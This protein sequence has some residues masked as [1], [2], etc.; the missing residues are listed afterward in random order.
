MGKRQHPETERITQ[1][2]RDRIKSD[3]DVKLV[4]IERDLRRDAGRGEEFRQVLILGKTVSH[5]LV[6]G[7]FQAAKA[8]MRIEDLRKLPRGLE[9]LDPVGD[10]FFG[11]TDSGNYARFLHMIAKAFFGQ[12]LSMNGAEVAEA[13]RQTFNGLDP[14]SATVMCLELDLRT[15]LSRRNEQ[16]LSHLGEP[17]WDDDL[18]FEPFSSYMALRPWAHDLPI[19]ALRDSGV[20]QSWIT[21]FIFFIPPLNQ[22]RYDDL[23]EWLLWTWA[24]PAEVV[25]TEFPIEKREYGEWKNSWQ[26][27]LSR[28]WPNES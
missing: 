6:Q 15:E 21:A 17:F 4:Q 26:T 8:D 27:I 12:G 2:I 19:R 5:G 23:R 25:A 1:F 13:N 16:A 11:L 10:E 28:R 24:F 9:L 7:I 18:S 22:P 20:L 14:F 3:P